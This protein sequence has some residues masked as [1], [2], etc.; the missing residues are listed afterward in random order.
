MAVFI[1]TKK[2][3]NDPDLYKINSFK[4]I[5][6]KVY[7]SDD[8][9]EIFQFKLNDSY[10]DLCELLEYKHKNLISLK[11]Y[12]IL[13]NE[14]KNV[15]KESYEQN[16]NLFTI[17]GNEKVESKGTLEINNNKEFI[18]YYNAP[19]TIVFNNPINTYT[20]FSTPIYPEPPEP[21]FNDFLK[22]VG[23]LKMNE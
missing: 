4:D 19:K 7:N 16:I 11:E 20:E 22:I 3:Y 5:Q 1:K 21:D 14:L 8:F 12:L 23:C 9:K 13:K 6:T 2:D 15:Y 17:D 18:D 10:C